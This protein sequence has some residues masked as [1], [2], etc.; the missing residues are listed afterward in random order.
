MIRKLLLFLLL[1][2][3]CLGQVSNST[4]AP[5]GTLQ[6]QNTARLDGNYPVLYF[7]QYA[8]FY[9]FAYPITTATNNFP[10]TITRS[11]FTVGKVINTFD[12][13][14]NDI[15]QANPPSVTLTPAST[16]LELTAASTGT[17]TLNYTYTRNTGTPIFTEI[18]IVGNGQTLYPG[19]SANGGSG[20]QSVTYPSNVTTTYTFTGTTG[21]LSASDVATISYSA[22][23]YFGRAAGTVPSQSEILAAA[24]GG[25]ALSASR[26]GTFVITASG[27]N[28]P[29][30][31]YPSSLGT[32]TSIKDASGV[33]FITAYNTGT[34]SLTNALGYVQTYRYYVAQNATAGNTTMVTQ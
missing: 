3:A 31:A 5:A 25:S 7:G 30:F 16:V 6:T 21:S 29:Y 22:R 18:K 12:D 33:E 20:S 4:T 11:T 13:L 14:K 17:S 23:R 32:L 2:F 27:S 15:S 1:P 24:G 10:F 26:A 34:L 28:Y 8:G 9:R 19:F